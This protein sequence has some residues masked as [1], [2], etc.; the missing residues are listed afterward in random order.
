MDISKAD[1]ILPGILITWHLGS[2]SGN[3]IADVLFGDYNP[4]GKL[5]VSFPRNVGQLPL[6]YNYKN[7]GRPTLP[8]PDVVFWS[9]YQDEKN[10]ALYPFG[11]GLSYTQFEYEN[12]V[13]K[14]KANGISV[15]IDVKNIGKLTGKEVVQLY[16]RDVHA[17]ITRPVKELKGFELVSLAPNEVKTV[18]FTLTEKELGFYNNNGAFTVEPGLF[19]LFVGGSSKTVIETSFDFK[20]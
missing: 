1:K 15:K 12:L 13:V 16:I 4:S 20:G 6:Y 10:S 11:H 5:P 3:A 9:H 2:Q 19:R 17:S 18:S 14:P 7:T 8:A